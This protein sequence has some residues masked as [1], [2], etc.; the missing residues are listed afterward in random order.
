MPTAGPAALTA[1]A[2]IEANLYMVLATADGTG[3]P[4]SSPVYFAEF[5]WVSSPGVTHSR[6]IA[7]RPE[8]GIAVFDSQVAIG[9]GQGLYIRPPPRKLLPG[10]ATARGI[11]AFSPP[12]GRPWRFGMDEPTEVP[13]QRRPATL[14]GRCRLALDPC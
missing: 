1:R 8:V 4:W 12:F 3:R 10:R 5:F 2:I 13:A 7:V 11:E 6:N 9:A 14:S